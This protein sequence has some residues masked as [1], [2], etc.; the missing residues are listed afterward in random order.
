LTLDIP[1]TPSAIPSQPNEASKIEEIKAALVQPIKT[2]KRQKIKEASPAEYSQFVRNIM[3]APL[4]LSESDSLEVINLT[5]PQKPV[6]VIPTKVI[7]ASP[8]DT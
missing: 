8:I 5:R 4:D 6:V 3:N 7:Q 1:E 2:Q